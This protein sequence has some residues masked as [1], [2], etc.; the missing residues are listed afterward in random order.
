MDIL[1][2]DTILII[3]GYLKPKDILNL[4]LVN[5]FFNK[6]IKENELDINITI[7]EKINERNINIFLNSHK[8]LNLTFYDV[9]IN[10]SAE[11]LQYCRK[12]TLYSTNIKPECFKKLINC[13][14][15]YITRLDKSINK[16]LKNIKNI[17]KCKKIDL[18]NVNLNK[19]SAKLIN[20]INLESLTI[21]Y[22]NLFNFLNNLNSTTIKSLKLFTKNKRYFKK[23][24]ISCKLPN[25]EILRFGAKMNIDDIKIICKNFPKLKQ[26]F[27]VYD[28]NDSNFIK[29]LSKLEYLE[30]LELYIIDT[31]TDFSDFAG[32]KNLQYLKINGTYKMKI[33]T[34][35]SLKNLTYLEI[36][37]YRDLSNKFYI[38][39]PSLKTIKTEVLFEIMNVFKFPNIE[40]LL[41]CESYTSL[42]FS[43]ELEKLSKMFINLD[44]IYLNFVDLSRTDISDKEIEI[45][46]RFNLKYLNLKFCKLTDKSLEI[47]N[48]PNLEYL[49]ISYN[50]NISNKG[51][52]KLK[53]PKL[54]HLELEFCYITTELFELLQMPRLCYINVSYCRLN[55]DLIEILDRRY[56]DFPY[57]KK[58]KIRS[59]NI[60]RKPTKYDSLVLKNN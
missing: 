36:Y 34:T 17:N 8:F 27:L 12:I 11:Y 4:R 26:L 39:F 35:C 50:D 51:V 44:A 3:L 6:I 60:K 53:A 19:K 5:K 54:K 37:Y 1:A 38:E 57:L 29:C 13:H 21:N 32:L 16:I 56:K 28:D 58:I 49:N 52:L 18:V 2:L 9:N 10:E 46:N 14:S 59:K 25:L 40:S 24:V 47:M 45:L 30:T 23:F 41:L 55:E 15:I 22:C 7:K 33:S 42:A 43:S 48:F 31:D 20:L